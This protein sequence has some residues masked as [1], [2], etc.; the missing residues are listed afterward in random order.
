MIAAIEKAVIEKEYKIFF[1]CAFSFAAAAV[2][3]YCGGHRRPQQGRTSQNLG[4]KEALLYD[5]L[6]YDV[7]C[8][9]F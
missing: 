4:A 3:N 6:D 5:P 9:L 2:E 1:Y 7:S 8:I